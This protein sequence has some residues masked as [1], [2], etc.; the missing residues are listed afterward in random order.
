MRSP[1]GT[2]ETMDRRGVLVAHGTVLCGQHGPRRSAAEAGMPMDWY[3]WRPELVADLVGIDALW[4]E[5]DRSARSGDAPE[6]VGSLPARRRGG[7]AGHPS[8][9]RLEANPV[10][11]QRAMDDLIGEIAVLKVG[12]GTEVRG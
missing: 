4:I 12:L 10:E 2:H 7:P 3:G 8:H 5:A 9:D 6:P 1:D 11:D